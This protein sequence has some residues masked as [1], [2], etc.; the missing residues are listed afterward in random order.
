MSKH[1]SFPVRADLMEELCASDEADWMHARYGASHDDW[2]Q[3]SGTPP[4]LVTPEVIATWPKPYRLARA[5]LLFR[6]VRPDL[7][8]IG[9]LFHD[10]RGA[11]GFLETRGLLASVFDQAR[12]KASEAGYSPEQVA[13]SF[14]FQAAP[15]PVGHR[16]LSRWA[17]HIDVAKS[18]ATIVDNADGKLAE[19]FLAHL[20]T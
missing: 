17:L 14:L 3:F 20:R 19:K 18:R 13:E 7:P 2:L 5:Y 16:V 11:F 12:R 4:G 10:E 8:Q 15:K 9:C 6:Y 1:L